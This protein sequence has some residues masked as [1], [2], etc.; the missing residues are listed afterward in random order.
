MVGAVTALNTEHDVKADVLV[1]IALIASVGTSEFFAAGEVAKR[2]DGIFARHTNGRG[3][4]QAGW[5]V[6]YITGRIYFLF[7]CTDE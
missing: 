6:G 4:R 5:S 3:E 2:V 1:S 7:N